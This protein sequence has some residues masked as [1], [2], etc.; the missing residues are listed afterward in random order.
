MVRESGLEHDLP[1]TDEMKE[2]I[3][4]QYAEYKLLEKRLGNA[5]RMTNAPIVKFDPAEYK[6]LED[7]RAECKK[8]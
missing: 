4:S 2:L 5:A 8:N 6:A 3:L 7:L 1:L